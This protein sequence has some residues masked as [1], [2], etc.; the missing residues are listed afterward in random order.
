VIVTMSAV[1]FA[2]RSRA[3]SLDVPALRFEPGLTLLVGDNGAGKSTLLRIAAGVQR[4]DAGTVTIDGH[5][6]WL[7]EVETRSLLAYVPDEPDLVPY[8]SV[9]EILLLVA[10]LRHEPDASAERA[11][12][13]A[14]LRAFT[15]S[16]PHALSL[17]Q[18][19]RIAL[20]AAR[21]GAPPVLLLDDPLEALDDATRAGVLGW[22]GAA[23]TGGATVVVSTHELAPFAP[24][25]TARVRLAS[26]HLVP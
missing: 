8:A 22:V 5:D 14:G 24:W 18:Q 10:R 2:Y 23:L 13:E 12:D 3:F 9:R 11:L 16:S 1:R 21:I 4:P 26:G 6:L 19:R 7:A 25:E 17:G 20:A 15:R